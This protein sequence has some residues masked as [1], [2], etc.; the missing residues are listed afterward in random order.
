MT[1]SERHTVVSKARLE[2]LSDGVFSIVMT[3]LVFQLVSPLISDAKTAGELHSAL[4]VLWPT[5]VSFVIS[6]IMLGIFWV[7]H[8][9]YLSLI[10]I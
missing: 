1:T 5:F 3:L 6:F 2:A 10:H 9:S 8:H 7:G 4:L